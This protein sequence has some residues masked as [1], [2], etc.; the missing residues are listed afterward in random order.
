M[1]W[2]NAVLVAI[3]LFFA[4]LQHN[5]TDPLFWGPAYGLAAL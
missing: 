1:R 5:D 3:L 4:A 2:L